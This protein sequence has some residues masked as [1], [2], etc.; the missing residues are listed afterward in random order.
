M[1]KILIAGANATTED[2]TATEVTVNLANDSFAIADA[3]DSN[4][5][6][7]DRITDV[8]AAIAGGN[9]LTSSSGV[10][11]VS[12]LTTT[13]FAA[14]TLVIESEGI[15]NNDNDTTI[16]TCAAIKDF[17]DTQVAAG[18]DLDVS[19]GSNT[20]AIANNETLEIGGTANEVTVTYADGSSKFTISLPNDV[21]TQTLDLTGARW[22]Y[23]AERR[24]HHQRYKWH[25]S[26]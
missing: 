13:E 1:E 19:D 14:A 10:M 25:R 23:A 24:D 21:I 5:I 26:H 2:I 6:A 8:V 15:A 22:S 12:G 4:I 17:V 9:G 20:G 7:R 18:Y 16:A 3:S 11:S